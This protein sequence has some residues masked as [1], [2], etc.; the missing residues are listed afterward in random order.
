MYPHTTV[1]GVWKKAASLVD[2]ANAIVPAPRFDINDKMV[3]L[4][5]GDAPYLVRISEYKNKCN[6]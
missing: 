2:E 5:S 3:K 1:E 4:K 6:D